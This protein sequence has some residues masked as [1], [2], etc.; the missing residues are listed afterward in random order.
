MRLYRTVPVYN[1]TD[2]TYFNDSG[3]LVLVANAS[4]TV[5][6]TYFEL[7]LP[8]TV[9]SP[10]TGAVQSGYAL[11]RWGSDPL[12]MG[13]ATYAGL[14]GTAQDFADVCAPIADAGA[15]GRARHAIIG[16]F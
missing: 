7:P 5:T 14:G 8:R 11:T 15:C 9:S 3:T 6:D 1:Y 10:A 16:N 4:V 12:T 2:A 13:A